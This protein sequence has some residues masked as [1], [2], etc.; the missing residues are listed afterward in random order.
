ME[1]CIYQLNDYSLG[2]IHG[3]SIITLTLTVLYKMN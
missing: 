3:I 2:G 1:F